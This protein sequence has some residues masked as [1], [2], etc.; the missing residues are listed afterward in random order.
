[1]ETRWARSGDHW[2]RAP[3]ARSWLLLIRLAAAPLAARCIR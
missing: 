2:R 1:V 3:P